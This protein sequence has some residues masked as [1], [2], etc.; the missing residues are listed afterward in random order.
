M[1][2]I[3]L[4]ISALAFLCGS[5]AFATCGFNITLNA[6]NLTW[7]P[8]FNYV[9]VTL[10]LQ[11]A[12]PVACTADITF[13]KGHSSTYTRYVLNGG[14]NE[15]DYQLYGDSSLTHILKDAPDVSTINDVV[16]YTFSS[17]PNQSQVLTYYFQIPQST[18][19]SPTYKPY[20]GY[21]DNVVVR[22]WENTS[23]NP[24][25]VSSVNNSTPVTSTLNLNI[26]IPQIIEL[27]FGTT[28]FNA[29]NITQTL[30]F[31]DVTTTK[32]QTSNILVLSN[33]GYAISFTSTNGS[34]LKNTTAPSSA[35]IPYTFSFN[36]STLPLSTS[37][38][39][40]I[41]SSRITTSSGDSFP[42][43]ITTQTTPSVLNGNFTDSISVTAVTTQ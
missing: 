39:Q 23:G 31:G 7:T 25:S 14:S 21:S 28:T 41:N 3:K 36:G 26:N 35:S 1:K 8:S 17:A 42:I 11:K 43:S 4:I 34:V 19:T 29:A 37:P 38:S 2:N 15:L 6:I 13:G 32:T 27:C 5:N 33:A 10:T 24:N 12:S 40:G 18:A 30:N 20:G 9:A 22:V 16:S